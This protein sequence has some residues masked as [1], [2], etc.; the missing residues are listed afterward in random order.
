MTRVGG[1]MT[2]PGPAAPA[3]PDI[4]ATRRIARLVRLVLVAMIGLVGGV[5]SWAATTPL[6]GAVIAQGVFVVDSYSKKVQH[7]SG[8]VV[9][10]IRV[11]NG[12]HVSE[13][14]ILVRLDE[15]QARANLQVLSGQLDQL[16]AVETRLRA[17]QQ[18]VDRLT[19][20]PDLADRA[21]DPAVAAILAAETRLFEN[22]RE[23]RAGQKSQLVERSRQLE[24]EISGLEAQLAANKRETELIGIELEGVRELFQKKLTPLTRLTA[25][26][27][28][29][30]RLDG[31]RGR[32]VASIAQSRGRI[33]EIALQA[34][35]IDQD[36]RSEASR[37]LSDVQ[38]RSAE[39]AER[40]TAAVDILKRVDI[41]SPRNGV[42]H[43]LALHTLG[44]VIGAG[45][46]LMTIVPAE[47]SLV[48]EAR[49]APQ[50][51]DRISVGQPAAIRL[52]AFN[53]QTTPEVSARVI[54]ISAD[55]Q[56]DPQLNISYYLARLKLDA[57][58]AAVSAETRLVPGM[59]AEV[60]LKTGE[61]T[62][63]SFLLKPLTDQMARSFRE[64]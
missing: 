13:G 11:K 20:P 44:G 21:G 50:E 12:D 56:R 45:E 32:L 37:L 24:N 2:A 29:A 35:Q 49:I 6:A 5:G 19:F 41:R 53:Q 43:E 42:V 47:D 54:F 10:E 39:L 26:E 17:E 4:A 31:D 36:V 7:P 15:T 23:A 48:V 1:A 55:L 52:S 27:R 51:V 33:A 57:G 46:P 3:D 18:D 64:D 58:G 25:L 9:A 38:A 14:D 40:R 61:R 28:D 22:R 60:H 34:I 16:A 62:A 8:G 30:A 59:P 63:L